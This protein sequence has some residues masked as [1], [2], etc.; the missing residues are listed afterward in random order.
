[1]KAL[2]VAVCLVCLWPSLAKAI[3][4]FEI[5]SP[6]SGTV[7]R[8]QMASQLQTV[9]E[10]KDEG[11]GKH[12]ETELF[13]RA[14][15]IRPTLTVS[16][17]K[18]QTTFKLHLSTAP[19]SIEL[20]DLYFET[21]LFPQMSLRAGQYKIPFTRYRIQSFQRLTLV[22]WAI[23]TKYFGAERQIGFSVHNGYEKPPRFAYAVG[24]FSGVNARASHATGLA[25]LFGEKVINP[26]DL[27]GSAP[28]DEF[29]PE[30]VCHL[31]CNSKNIDVRT[32]S[33]AEGG[34]IRYSLA[35]SAAWDMAPTEFEDLAVR[36]AQEF[37]IKYRHLSL[38]SAGYLGFIKT[39]GSRR[40]R[41]AMTGLLVQSA[42]RAIGRIEF[43]LRYSVVDIDNT[44]ANLSLSRA[45]SI[46]AGTEDEFI[47]TQY[48][49]AGVVLAEHEGTLGFNVYLDEHNLKIQNDVGFTRHLRRDGNRTDYLIRS[50]IQLSF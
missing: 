6:D 2:K 7:L 25:S 15:R 17:P 32:D 22:D 4:P 16:V 49:N 1:L 47:I 14:R 31:A 9:L 38:M 11:T 37:L 27:T 34:G 23:V 12:R 19:G 18:F 39:D 33:D 36:V 41:R 8:L 43:S 21:K 13:M 50:Q 42:C 44:I 46:I 24:I 40:A 10:S 26:S 30:L 5:S 29:H 48:K 35:T 20:M 3:G 45:Q 28:K